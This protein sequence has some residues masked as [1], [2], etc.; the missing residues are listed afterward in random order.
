MSILLDR[1]HC[2]C[3]ACP[4]GGIPDLQ[5]QMLDL[6]DPLDQNSVDFPLCA[7]YGIKYDRSA[8]SYIHFCL[9]TGANQHLGMILSWHAASPLAG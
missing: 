2:R 1:T 5:E 8:P 3:P 6:Y 7:G 4:A 9:H